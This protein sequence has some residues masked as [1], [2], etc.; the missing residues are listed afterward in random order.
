M[1]HIVPTP[2][3]QVV[4]HSS[5]TSARAADVR[6]EHGPRGA[7]AGG[8][9][10]GAGRLRAPDRRC[11]LLPASDTTSRAPLLAHRIRAA[12]DTGWSGEVR[13][14]GLAR[15]PADRL[16]LR[17]R[18]PAARRAAPTC[19]SGGG[20]TRTGGSTGSRPTGETDLVR[21]G[22]LSIRWNY[23]DNTARLV[24][25]YSPIRLPDDNDVVPAALARAA[26]RRGEG[27][28]SS[29]GSRH[30]AWP[31]AAPPGCGW[32]RRTRARRSRGSTCGPTS[33]PALP[34][35]VDVYGDR[36]RPAP[37]PDQRGHRRSTDEP[38][39]DRGL[40]FQFSRRRRLPPRRRA[41]TPWPR[42]NAFAPFLLPMQAGRAASGRAMPPSSAPSVSTAADRPPCSSYPCATPPPRPCTSS[43]AKSRNARDG[44]PER[45]PRGRPAVGAAGSAYPSPSCTTGNFLLA[46]TV[47]PAALAAGGG[48]APATAV[49][50]TR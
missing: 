29:R 41:S 26:A 5:S 31:A 39:S 18:R 8:G 44:R 43:C 35:R 10:A 19:G 7:L 4:A 33:R 27:R 38:P 36:R 24:T 9:A 45:R 20:T 1:A 42:A 17:R 30:D 11:A 49:L 2:S 28:A 34:L 22:G 40:R 48:R 13:V 14:P 15:G 16:D 6:C 47:T 3:P 37:D 12:I 32:C 23:E 46:G 21:D 50:R 25:P